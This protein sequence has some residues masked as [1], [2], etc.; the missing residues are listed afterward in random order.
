MPP[1]SRW[2]ERHNVLAYL[3][4]VPALW[5]VYARM[6]L[7]YITRSPRN[8]VAFF[9]SDAI[10]A[11]GAVS[12]TLLVAERFGGIG[13][14]SRD[15]VLFMLGYAAAAT[16]MLELF[17]SFNVRFISRRLGRGQLDH[18]LI[19]PIPMPVALLTEGFMPFSG[20][21]Q[22]VPGTFLLLFAGSRVQ[23]SPT[24]T[25]LLLFVLN[26]LA[27]AAIALSFSFVWGSLAFWAPRAAEEVSTSANRT[28][29]QLKSFPLDGAAGAL[30]V[31]L[32]TFV[33]V[34]LLAWYPSRALLGLDPAPLAPYLTPIAA[35]LALALASWTFTRG[36]ARYRR[37]G[38]TR[39]LS[40]GFRR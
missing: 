19:Q 7:I 32:L 11:V 15:Q 37:V 23:L 17:F 6:D 35:L 8:F 18:T 38:S 24:P 34:G 36:L 13:G 5:L 28:L 40:F 39:Y 1:P 30:V 22:L 14:W 27:S 21:A 33:P 26:L 20:A 9:L 3:A 31:G 2:A 12:T 25:F 16:G 10:L 4:R 29:D